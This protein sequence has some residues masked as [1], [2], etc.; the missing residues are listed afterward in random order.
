[1][2]HCGLHRSFGMYNS[3]TQPTRQELGQRYHPWGK[4]PGGDWGELAMRKENPRNIKYGGAP[5][6]DG[7]TGGG[8]QCFSAQRHQ[9]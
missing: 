2:Q 1:M 8:Y 4:T 6:E 7:F 5:M 3:F 9:I